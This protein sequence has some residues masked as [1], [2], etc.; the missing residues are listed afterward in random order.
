MQ[1]KEKRFMYWLAVLVF[2]TAVLA[3]TNVF[4]AV[5]NVDGL[6][7]VDLKDVITSLQ[8][9][10]GLAPANVTTAG[11]VNADGKI[12]LAEAV[13][14]L[15]VVAKIRE[16]VKVWY[17]DADGDGYSDG[18]TLT[19]SAQ[20]SS[21]YYQAADLITTSGDKDDY[22]P[23]VHP[24]VIEISYPVSGLQLT[25]TIGYNGE[26]QTVIGS[27][28]PRSVY[29]GKP[30][31]PVISSM[32][33][34]PNGH[35]LDH[36]EVQ[37]GEK[38]VLSGSHTVEF[39]QQPYPLL[40][41]VQP[42]PTPMDMSVYGSD[43][44]YPGKLH[45][46][47]G[48]QKLA[49]IPILM[50][51]LNPVE[52]KPLSGQLSYYKKMTIRVVTN[53]APQSRTSYP[54]RCNPDAVLEKMKVDNPETLETYAGQTAD[55]G[56]ARSSAICNPADSYRYVLITSKAIKDA[57]ATPNVNDLIAHRQAQG[58]SATIVTTEDI[59][60]N[61]SGSDNAEKVRNFIIDAYNNWETEF[62]LLGGD[63]NII[64]M[65]K[66]WCEPY[67]NSSCRDPAY[68]CPDYIPSDLYYQC[69]DG[70]YNSDGDSKWGEPNDGINGGD[71]DLLA[72]VYVGRASAE[73]ATEMSNFIYKTISFEND[74]SP[75]KKSALM[76]GEY[77]FKDGGVSEY[78]KNSMEEI[79]LG[80]TQHGISTAGFT[81]DVS[82]TVGTLYDKDGI[83]P[84]ST[85]ISKINANTYGMINHLGHAYSNYAMKML[86]ADADALT[87][88]KFIFAYSQGCIPGNFEADCM[89]E[90]LTTSTRKG[91]FA[92]VF[93][94]RYGWGKS[95]S[96]DGA[97]HRYNREFWDAMFREGK[98]MLG[99]M[100][101]DS[102]EDNAWRIN[103][104]CMRWCYY[105]SNLLGDPATSLVTSSCTYSISPVSKSFTASAGTGSVR[106][107]AGSGCAW[108]AASNNTSWLTVTSGASVTGNGTVAYSVAAN[109]GA[110]RTGTI[111]IAG[112][113][114]T[115]T[116]DAPVPC[117]YSISPVSKS[118]TSS[119]G[120]GSISVTAG[121]GCAWTAVSNN[122]SWL[123]VT[124]GASVTGNG[125]V[126][127]S[128]AAN[129]GTARTGT[130]T[131]A[132]KTFT[133]TQS[134]P[135]T[136]SISPVSNSFTS[137]AGTGS[138]SVTAGTGCAWTAVSNNTSW[139][140]VT[141]GAGLTGN[142]TVA[143]SVAA[144]TGTSSR[145]GT[146]TIAGKTFTVTQ[147]APCT[148]SIS[149]VSNSFTS[150]AGTG[151]VTVIAGTGCAWTAVSNNTSW[152]TV[153]SG[154]SVTGNGTVGYSVTANTG[155]A[156]TGTISI[157]GKTFTVTQPAPCTYSISPISNSFTSSA[158]TG[159]VSV[160]AGSG[161]AWT[162]VSNAT[163]ITV[164]SGGS[165]TG[166]GTVGYSVADSTLCSARTGT[167]TV[168]GKTFTVTQEAIVCSYGI[169]PAGGSIG[170]A[171]GTG[172]FSVNTQSCCAWTAVSNASWITVSSGS[173]GTG[174]GTVGYSVAASTLCTP[175]TG[176]VTVA[177]K[178]FTVTQEAIA[179]SH[180]TGQ[181]IYVTMTY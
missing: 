9:D 28:T 175:R 162:A 98:N 129:T 135:C 164:T 4:G 160:T 46:T 81:S 169:N 42:L 148:Y 155:A 59:Y 89:A 137:S 47:T 146:I 37:P 26:Q 126:G 105:E 66:L 124:S 33:V 80:S 114:F 181:K 111:T 172:S 64:P 17:K 110:A 86:N 85:L 132:G 79:R 73:N 130:I 43:A 176:T 21:Q 150:S 147:S 27:S 127:Y 174:N 143:Y 45:D 78:A 138:V 142:G 95:N 82:F 107:T 11:D 120:T 60:A 156:R 39:G 165:G 134:A 31:L 13:Y 101:A 178:T 163:W 93:N 14:G 173:S 62:I 15:Q 177:D 131:I 87:N 115:V 50:A 24:E 38:T 23:L 133:V 161:C 125:T 152:L 104:A 151:S 113:T 40:P 55:T 36:I 58:M 25:T 100:N 18:T 109:T 34:L 123:T 153:T 29:T 145:T 20:P 118:F 84:K 96:T 32:I 63:T 74:S 119:A 54:L 22:A 171:G 139:L 52:Y 65:R 77:L 167:I 157:A 75:F 117:T 99:M 67:P 48:I 121:S 128:V 49:G 71:V 68:P 2:G 149:P 180:S 91:M 170:S 3:G 179:C 7:E 76:C 16:A 88:T 154:T 19:A 112:K 72:E 97:S 140:T 61:Y 1:R 35:E 159:S 70:S 103:E 92:V 158:G 12:G 41:D 8:V 166:N 44:P 69:L 141:S 136:Y 144:N 94:S 56:T 57:A 102:H 122:T 10:A 106:V 6:G 168:A 116:Q 83:W 53:P 108:T 90:H 51:T 5:G 30:I